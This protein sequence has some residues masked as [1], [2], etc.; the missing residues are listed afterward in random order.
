MCWRKAVHC[1]KAGWDLAW[2]LPSPCQGSGSVLAP[3][4]IA[5]V[6]VVAGDAGLMCFTQSPP[7]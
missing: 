3:S 6:G 2:A 4:S 1:T 7:A 5:K